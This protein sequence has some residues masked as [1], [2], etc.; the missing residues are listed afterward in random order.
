MLRFFFFFGGE[1]EYGPWVIWTVEVKPLILNHV[2]HMGVSYF[3]ATSPQKI[4]MEVL[5]LTSL[6]A[7]S[8]K[9]QP[10]TENE[11]PT[12]SL[13]TTSRGGGGLEHGKRLVFFPSFGAAGCIFRL[14]NFFASC[15]SSYFSPVFF[16]FKTYL[17][18]WFQRLESIS[19]LDIFSN[20]PICGLSK[21]M[22]VLLGGRGSEQSESNRSSMAN[23]TQEEATHIPVAA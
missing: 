6:K 21:G 13:T 22:L 17:P 20:F 16:G 23:S 11:P 10:K 5:L 15:F 14:L 19:L 8:Q 1:Q 12:Y 9:G 3:C 2:S 4:K 18:C 7:T